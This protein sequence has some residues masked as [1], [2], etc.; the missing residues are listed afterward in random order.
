VQAARRGT[1][2]GSIGELGPLFSV[3]GAWE[4]VAVITAE[5]KA[6][7][8]ARVGVVDLASARARRDGK[9]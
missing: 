5:L 6:R 9:G 2:N 1:G 3:V 7:R 8:E 4:T